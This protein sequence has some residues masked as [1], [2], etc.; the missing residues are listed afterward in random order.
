MKTKSYLTVLS[1]LLCLQ[2]FAQSSISTMI[3]SYFV[4]SVDATFQQMITKEVSFH[5]GLGVGIPYDSKRNYENSSITST[6]RGYFMK[7]GMR[8]NILN[9]YEETSG[10]FGI[11]GI[12]SYVDTESQILTESYYNDNE[13][14]SAFFDGFV[15]AASL[16]GGINLS[17]S[18]KVSIEIGVRYNVYNK[19]SSNIEISHY[20]QP[21]LGKS[22]TL[23]NPSNMNYLG[24]FSNL[25]FQL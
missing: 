16:F 24:L 9:S 13:Q 20:Y 5:G 25:R 11:E 19:L 12:G 6:S 8:Y 21:G 2:G 3:S 10:F 23:N 18:E 22:N 7:A 1:L 15:P 17:L 14:F 4:G